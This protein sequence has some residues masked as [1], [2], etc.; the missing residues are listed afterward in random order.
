[1]IVNP[2]DPFGYALN[3]CKHLRRITGGTIKLPIIATGRKTAKID[4]TT[5]LQN[6]SLKFLKRVSNFNDVLVNPSDLTGRDECC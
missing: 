5:A 1:M 2:T 4:V 3:V 6:A